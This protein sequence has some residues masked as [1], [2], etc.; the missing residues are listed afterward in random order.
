MVWAQGQKDWILKKPVIWVD[1]GKVPTGHTQITR[2][3]PWTVLPMLLTRAL[4]ETEAAHQHHTTVANVRATQGVSVSQ[5]PTVSQSPVAAQNVRVAT[6]TAIPA[7]GARVLVVDDSLAVRTHLRSLLESKGA[8]VMEVDSGESAIAATQTNTFAC[9]LMDVLM[10][11]I[12]GYE[13]C[14]NIKSRSKSSDKALP[15]VML[16][17]R[18]SPFDKIRGKMSGCD[19]YLTKPVEEKHFYEVLSRYLGF[20]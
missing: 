8:S 14:R 18:S 9:V 20:L 4:Q 7:T 16:T 1:A 13:A 2:P 12:D 6:N 15:I 11:G 19:A 10:P 17:S 3:V 5:S